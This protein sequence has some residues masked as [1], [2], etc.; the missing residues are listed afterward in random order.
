[1]DREIGKLE[2]TFQRDIATKGIKPNPLRSLETQ[3]TL[4]SCTAEMEKAYPNSNY[5]QRLFWSEQ[6]K[7][8]NAKFP[9][10]MR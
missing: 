7:V 9:S 5:F 2:R 1:M 4:A 6:F 8:L 3:D 10:G